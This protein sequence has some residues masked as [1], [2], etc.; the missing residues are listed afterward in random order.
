[1]SWAAEPLTSVHKVPNRGA[2]PAIPDQ[3]GAAEVQRQY[4]SVH[5]SLNQFQNETSVAIN[6]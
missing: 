3:Q 5:S 1:M 4:Q 2:R 6:Q